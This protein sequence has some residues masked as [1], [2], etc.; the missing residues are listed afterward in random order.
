MNMI[1]TKYTQQ[2]DQGGKTHTANLGNNDG[3]QSQAKLHAPV[4]NAD[5]DSQGQTTT[6]LNL[7]QQTSQRSQDLS[8]DA[9]V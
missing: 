1:K 9:V 7:L 4:S 8:H 6:Q 5:L 3:W 2:Q